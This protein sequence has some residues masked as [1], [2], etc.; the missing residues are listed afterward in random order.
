MLKEKIGSRHL[1][2]KSRLLSVLRRKHI[3]LD[4]CECLILPKDCQGL[5]CLQHDIVHLK[6]KSLSL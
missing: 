4:L 3:I 6:G 2:F 5:S 1:T